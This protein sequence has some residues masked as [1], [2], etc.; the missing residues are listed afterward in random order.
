MA[1]D[2]GHQREALGAA[3]SGRSAVIPA[4]RKVTANPNPIKGP[5]R[6]TCITTGSHHVR[7]GLKWLDAGQTVRRGQ[8]FAQIPGGRCTDEERKSGKQSGV[9][10][11]ENGS[12]QTLQSGPSTKVSE[13][14]A[15]FTFFCFLS[16][17]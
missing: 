17:L 13:W 7:I 9:L 3:D 4:L 5:V 10:L 1:V 16:A 2:D 6:V 14:L 11:V 12:H 8:R 15:R